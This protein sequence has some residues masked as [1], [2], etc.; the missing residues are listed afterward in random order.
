M[1]HP[2]EGTIQSL[3]DGEL[4]AE[5][6]ARLELHF[7]SCAACAARLA[8]ARGF[9]QEADRLVDMVVVPPASV[10]RRGAGRRTVVRSLAWAASIVVAVAAG[11]W[12]RGTTFTPPAELKEG[13]RPTVVSTSPHEDTVVPTTEEPAPVANAARGRVA[14]AAPRDAAPRPEAKVVDQVAAPPPAAA[15]RQAL[16][17]RANA[18]APSDSRLADEA[19]TAWRVVAMEEAVRVLGGQIRLIDGL[20]PSR[21]EIGPGTAVAGADPGLQVVRVVYAG[22]AV[23]LDQQRPASVAGLH[24]DAAVS[25]VA[26]RR[27]GPGWKHRGEIRFVV[28]GNVSADSLSALGAR[29]Q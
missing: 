18:V 12:G 13:D 3:L 26:A 4:D 22:G 8:E 27:A 11:Y 19:I 21:I 25:G 1:S 6:R 10:L 2:D 15:D 20:T 16:D 14:A 9:L 5:Q 28:T 29:V 23:M 17:A 7:R 24:K